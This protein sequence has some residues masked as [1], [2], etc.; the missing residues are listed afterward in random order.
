ME[1]GKE[2]GGGVCSCDEENTFKEEEKKKL[3]LIIEL[4]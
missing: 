1:M 2:I 3:K 4:W